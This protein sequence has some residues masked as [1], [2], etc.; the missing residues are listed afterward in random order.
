M[1]AGKKFLG[2]IIFSFFTILQNVLI[3]QIRREY[4]ENDLFL[5]SSVSPHLSSLLETYV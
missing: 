2:Y 5:K 1:K 4:F 3:L